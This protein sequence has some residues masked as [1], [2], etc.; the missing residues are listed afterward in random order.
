MPQETAAVV[1][2]SLT[3]PGIAYSRN[4]FGHFIEHFHRQIYGGLFAPG[5]PL[6]DE[7][8][9]REDVIE[10]MRELRPPVV[11]W[12][13]GC[14]VSSYHWL[15]GVGPT[16]RPHYDKA[17]RVTDPNT[18]GTHEFVAWCE[19]IGAAPYICT[20]AGTGTAE[21]MSDWVE[22]CNL[23]QGNGH[24]SDLRAAN[25]HP[26]PLAVPYWSIGNENYGDWEMGAKTSEEWAMLVRESAKMMLRV[27]E[28]AVLLTAARADLDWTLPLLREAG[29]YLDMVSIHGYWDKLHD[30]NEPSPYLTAIGRSLDPQR[31]IQHTIDIIGAASLTGKVS[32]AFDEWNLRGWHHPLGTSEAAINA[33]ELNEDN[34]TYTMADALFSAGFFNACLRRGDVVKMANIA[35][36][37]NTRGPLFVHPEGIVKRSTFHVM[38]MYAG[39]L[40]ERVL[41]SHGTSPELD[42]AGVPVVDSLA[43]LDASKSR[44]TLA[45]VNRD[46]A[47]SV[48]CDV[49]VSGHSVDGS[50][51]ATVLDGPDGDA[52]NDV[53]RPDAV[54]PRATKV[55]FRSGRCVLPPHSL[56]MCHIE[57]P[58]H[59]CEGDVDAGRMLSGDWRLSTAG[60]HKT[61]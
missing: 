6:S 56:T 61:S 28:S 58:F 49:R 17:W 26:E 9:F 41:D 30:V 34:S 21:E 25:G 10:A 55:E 44:I 59:H 60:W 40:G 14:F 46:P 18:F 53:D 38:A 3:H 24:W 29:R 8:G 11:R 32:I 54:T 7:R 1:D 33:R 27:D 35:P 45:L 5:S 31:E 48:A 22:Y 52:Y 2:V 12:P 23:P 20:N 47:A 13:G 15:D 43:T 16:R 4:V 19:A 37:I 50:Y 57:L 51:P 36:S 39:L 42:G